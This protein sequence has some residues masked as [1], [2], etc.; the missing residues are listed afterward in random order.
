MERF[1]RSLAET[2]SNGGNVLHPL[3]L[4][5]Q[6]EALQSQADDLRNQIRE[7]ERLRAGVDMVLAGDSIEDL[8]RLLVS[9]RVARGLTQRSLAERLG[10]QEQQIQKYE[11]TEYA[12]ASLTRIRE[13][14]DSLGVAVHQDVFLPLASFDAS[15]FFRRLEHVGLERQF[16]LTRLLPRRLAAR[17]QERRKGAEASALQAAHIV[18]RI[19]AWSPMDLIASADLQIGGPVVA[20]A[21]FKV[22]RGADLEKVSAYAVYAHYLALLLLEATDA[23]PPGTATREAATLRQAMSDQDGGV[24]YSSLLR[25]CWDQGMPVLPLRDAGAFHGAYWRSQGRGVIVLKQRTTSSSRWLFDLCHEWWHAGETPERAEL[26]HIEPADQHAE[27]VR[28]DEQRAMEFAGSVILGGRGDALADEVVSAAGGR[29]ERFKRLVPEVARKN[30]VAVGALANYMA[31]RVQF[32]GNFNWWP[33]A[34]N[35]QE[36]D[37]TDPW[38]LAR[39]VLL[40]RAQLARLN[41]HD[42]ELVE[43]AL[44]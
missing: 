21:R 20:A 18:A 26:Q 19:F 42:R 7:Y 38:T 44:Q 16:V 22:A 23:G 3:L 30:D 5:A 40:E 34:S 32:S 25:Y 28:E 8:P 43:R 6:R 14:I 10:L 12:G 1:E 11:A 13:V 33:V 4:R 31:Y 15:D 35:L 37:G 9:A 2:S 36:R 27:A 24:T 39:D 29:L 41:P 17:L